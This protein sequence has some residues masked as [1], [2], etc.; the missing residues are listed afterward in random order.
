M[1]KKSSLFIVFTFVLC[2]CSLGGSIDAEPSI[3]NPSSSNETSSEDSFPY[4]DYYFD[5]ASSN[6]DGTIENPYSSLLDIA[7]I[8]FNEGTRLFFKC[9]SLFSAPLEL[10]NLS[11][12]KDH[13]ILL[14]SYGEGSLP[15]IAGNDI[16]GKGVVY[17]LNCSC[18]I[19]ENLEIYDT[20]R[21]EKDRRGVLV[22][23]T[24]PNNTNDILTYSSIALRH[25][26]I[27]DIHGYSDAEN[28]GMATSSKITGGIHLWSKDGRA[29]IDGFE[30]S[31]CTIKNVSNVGIATWYQVNG[32]KVNKV[33]PYDS[34]FERSSHKN[35]LLARN[36]ISYIAKNGIFVRNLFGG[37]IIDNVLHDTATTCKAGNTIV[38]SYVDSTLVERNEGYRNM[39][40]KQSNG[41]FQDGAMLD[42]DLQSRNVI[43]QYNYSHDNSFGLFL[44][45]NASGQY[46]AGAKD[47]VTLRYNLSLADKG[48]KGII[49]L[50][51]YV[52]KVDCYNN[53]IVTSSS[54]SPILLQV[55]DD[56]SLQFYNNLIYAHSSSSLDLGN[57]AK[58]VMEKNLFYSSSSDIQNLND[59]IGDYYS[60]DPLAQ[61]NL[62]NDEFSRAGFDN[63]IVYAYM[64]EKRLFDSNHSVS[65]PSRPKD[66]LGN[67]YNN[68]IGCVN[69][70][71][72]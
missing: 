38:T 39:A 15:K 17:L 35:V 22:E 14:T 10:K 2:S 26:S 55:K 45:C 56:R 57:K 68:S 11:G 19:L 62:E 3:A 67:S 18:L 32:T 42:S 58:L 37:A 53:T 49:Y 47:N 24:N 28:A 23:L 9:G 33:S 46:D 8:T 6:G 71:I 44:N 34:K 54:T 70:N 61:R 48:N 29:R 43:F 21:T 65:I 40:Q 4:Q 7:K 20:S 72:A 41:K 59:V 36:E 50:N 16:S 1:L 60:F 63:G 5:S 69:Q 25:L 31:D 27:H 52:G 30:V 12:T 51:Y 13:P 66:I 64:G